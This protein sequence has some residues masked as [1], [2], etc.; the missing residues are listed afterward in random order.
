MSSDKP[1]LNKKT[2]TGV[3]LVALSGFVPQ[4]FMQQADAASASISVTG[5]FVTGV[6][7]AAGTSVKFGIF[8]ATDVNGSIALST[9]GVTTPSKAVAAG[10]APQ[11][12]SFAMTLVST[13]PNVDITIS[14]LGTVTLAASAG[15]GGPVGTVKL[16]KIILDAIGAAA[17]SLTDGGGG[18]AKSAGYN[19]TVKTGSIKVGGQLTW[20]AV[21]PIGTFAE[22]I[23]LTMAF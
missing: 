18:T 6:K 8:A 1:I 11:A 7:L 17:I 3:A 19:V 14:G 13:V 12:G 9:A 20:G 2:A 16:N 15:G 5:S 4:P 10:G 21:Q 22:A 23:V